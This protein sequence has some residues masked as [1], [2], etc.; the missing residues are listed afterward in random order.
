MRTKKRIETTTK[1]VGGRPPS[2][3]HLTSPEAI[4]KLVSTSRDLTDEAFEDFVNESGFRV[5]L[6]V[7]RAKAC[8][9]DVKAIDLYLKRCDEW[10]NVRKR[11]QQ[12]APP[13]I[14]ADQFIQLERPE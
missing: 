5:A 3:D 14:G 9:G 4:A 12:T 1:K 8:D 10:R 11:S 6:S 13:Q 7:L 2:L